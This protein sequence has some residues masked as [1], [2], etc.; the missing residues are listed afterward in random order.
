[1]NTDTIRISAGLPL[2]NSVQRCAAL[3]VLGM[4]LWS[5]CGQVNDQ[6]S[7]ESGAEAAPSAPLSSSVP[8]E[9]VLLEAISCEK[10]D[11]ALTTQRGRIVVVDTWATWCLPCMEE[12]PELVALH[13]KYA[14]DGVV[15]MSVSVDEPEQREFVEDFLNRQRADFANY[16]IADENN[17]W[18]DKWNIKGIPIVL[19]FDTEGKLIQKFDRDDP[20][21][22]FTYTDVEKLVVELLERNKVE[23]PR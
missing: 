11:L 6:L 18:W 7:V 10:W 5:G 21:N 1:M 20:D 12:F 8:K 4:S 16:L 14:K 2:K 19:V 15:C 9:N 13:E 17:A 3:F 22:Q 23:R